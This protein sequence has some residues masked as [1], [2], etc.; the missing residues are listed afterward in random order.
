MSLSVRRLLGKRIVAVHRTRLKPREHDPEID[1]AVDAIELED[2]RGNVTYL[3][4]LAHESDYE[5]YV[6]GVYPGREPTSDTV[7]R[8][9]KRAK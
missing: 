5:P 1:Y 7:A 3:H 6:G 2:E 8:V 4:L 9:R